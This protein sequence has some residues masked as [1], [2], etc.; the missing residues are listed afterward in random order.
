METNGIYKIESPDLFK[1]KECKWFLDRGFYDCMHTVDE[2]GV[3][4]LIRG[5]G[6]LVLFKLLT[7]KD[8]LCYKVLDGPNEEGIREEITGY[9]SEWFDFKADM[10][11][12]YEM[13][14]EDE[15]LGPLVEKYFGLRLI[16]IENLFEALCWAIIGQQVNLTFAYK[17]KRALVSKYGE[18]LH[19]DGNDYY[20]FPTASSVAKLEISD[21]LPLQ[22]SR[23]KA[24]YVIGLAKLF[25][26]GELDKRQLKNDQRLGRIVEELVKI[27]GIGPWTANYVAMRS[28]RLP[29]AFPIE[30]VGLHNAIKQCLNLEQ[31]PTIEEVRAIAKNWGMWKA[32]A[33]LFLWRSLADN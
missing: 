33:T 21:L 32:Y 6:G 17:I 18:H 11:P 2:E 19:Y 7:L 14:K 30:D 13:A 12:F 23:R 24:E 4:K 27:K 22:F 15:I 16:G 31:K 25:E 28:F 29:D 10:L 5:S 3:T 8:R 9:V 20:L 1:F 26:N